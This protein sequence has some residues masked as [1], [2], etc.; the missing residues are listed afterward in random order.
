MDEAKLV[1]SLALLC[2]RWNQSAIRLILQRLSYAAGALCW[3][4]GWRV[5]CRVIAATPALWQAGKQRRRR[6]ASAV[7]PSTR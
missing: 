3:S 1:W 5:Q 7:A 4:D 2:S 6:A